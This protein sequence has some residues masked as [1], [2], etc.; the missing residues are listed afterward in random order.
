MGEPEVL[1][2]V[3]TTLEDVSS[4]SGGAPGPRGA[5]KHQL[6]LGF[7]ASEDQCCFHGG[8]VLGKDQKCPGKVFSLR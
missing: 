8:P 6:G 5:A 4:S 1:R 2:D 3:E 7:F